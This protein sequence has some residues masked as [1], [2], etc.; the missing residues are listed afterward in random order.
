MTSERSYE[1]EVMEKLDELMDE[2]MDDQSIIHFDE[3]ARRKLL[4]SSLRQ[5]RLARKTRRRC[6][7]PGCS[8]RSVR[9][10]HTIQRNALSRIAEDGH[11][12]TPR[13]SPAKGELL[14]VP[15]GIGA[16]SVFPG[17]CSLHEQMFQ[18]FE[19]TGS[20]NDSNDMALQQFRSVC[21]EVVRV[22]VELDYIE[23]LLERYREYRREQFERLLL[24]RLSAEGFRITSLAA[25]D[26]TVQGLEQEIQQL[27]SVLRFLREEFYERAFRGLSDGEH[28][29]AVSAYK[30][31]AQVPVSLSGLVNFNVEE[32]GFTVNVRSIVTVIPGEQETLFSI[33]GLPEDRRHIEHYANTRLGDTFSWLGAIETWMVYGTDHWFLDP[34]VWRE[35]SE[36]AQRQILDDILDTS[37]NIGAIYPLGIFNRFRKQCLKLMESDPHLTRWE[38][39]EIRQQQEARLTW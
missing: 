24:Q 11:V 19:R 22:E 3:S 34:T 16:A 23:S 14:A 4:F 1:K 37:K 25:P 38:K 31:D 10:S 28:G 8:E 12:I 13:I 35:V 26:P 27:R 7:V 17:F 33:A 9:S 15:V 2:F 32:K 29:L 39:R 21:R 20:I 36:A 18:G 30:V 6:G 5:L